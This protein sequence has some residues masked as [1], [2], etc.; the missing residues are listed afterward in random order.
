MG[1]EH[2]GTHKGAPHRG[3]RWRDRAPD[4]RGAG[5][6]GGVPGRGRRESE[7]GTYRPAPVR[8]VL[9]PKPGGKSRPLGIPTVTD[10]VVQ[11]SFGWCCNR[12][13]SRLRA[14]L[15]RVPTQAA[16]HD[17]IAEIHYY[18]TRGYGG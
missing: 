18:A 14:G 5:Q 10:R 15:L 12:S 7:D 8:R 13:S 9:I 3:D 6:G 1:F 11:Q 2:S 4:P 17:A 16:A